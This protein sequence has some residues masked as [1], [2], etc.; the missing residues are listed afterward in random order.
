M[1]KDAAGN[2]LISLDSTSG[3]GL[4]VPSTMLHEAEVKCRSNGG[5]GLLWRC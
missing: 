1:G 5:T 2:L 4:S 3:A